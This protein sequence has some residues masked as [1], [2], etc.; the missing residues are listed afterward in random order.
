MGGELV[1]V[2]T[3]V[4]FHR[5]IVVDANLLV[6]VDRDNHRTYVGLYVCVWCASLCMCVQVGVNESSLVPRLLPS[7]MSR[8]VCD[9]KLGRSLGT[10]LLASMCGCSLVPR[11]AW[12]RGYVWM[13]YG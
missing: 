5:V 11:R 1:E 6:G 4:F 3:P 12:E 9:K 13:M 2:N 10:R 8:T 7:F